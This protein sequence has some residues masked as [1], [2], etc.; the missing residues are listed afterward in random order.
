MRSTSIRTVIELGMGDKTRATQAQELL[1]ASLP[2]RPERQA[3]TAPAARPD[4]GH[5]LGPVR[6]ALAI[7]G[8]HL[9]TLRRVPRL[10]V[11]ST[12]QPVVF[13]LLFRYVFGGVVQ[14]SQ[15]A[16]PYVEYLL[17]GILVQTTV[18]GA[19]GA[20]IGLA[21]DLQSGLVE[22]FR[23]LP[24][25]RSAVLA[26]RT[27]ADL[28][29]NVVVV[30]LMVVIGVAV[31]FR[32][33]TGPLAF[34]GGLLVVLVFASSM[35]WLFATLGLLVGDPET[36]QAAAFPVMAPLVFASSVFVPVSSMPGWLQPFATHQPISVTAS[37]VR[38]L[39]LG[40]P[41]AADLWQSLT[42]AAA[43]MTVSTPLAIWHYRR[44]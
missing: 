43:I 15:L 5:A 31:G 40:G 10:L 23:S 12:I 26:G 35:S 44:V 3:A 16:V 37:A 24:M 29:R 39:M 7:A 34:L 28:A 33:H 30:A 14:T 36:A 21:T 32:I 6:D 11:F 1:S 2:T 27:L 22:R 17:P 13:L 25:A 20:A 38:A 4:H 42:W 19:I 9:I 41:T 18:F 8:R